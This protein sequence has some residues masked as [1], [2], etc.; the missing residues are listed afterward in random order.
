M[1]VESENCSLRT[2]ARY[3]DLLPNLKVFSFLWI[4]RVVL[5]VFKKGLSHPRLK[6]EGEV[7]AQ[8]ALQPQT[9]L[10]LGWLVE[11]GHRV[12][13]RYLHLLGVQGKSCS[14]SSSSEETLLFVAWLEA[15]IFLSIA[16]FAS[17]CLFGCCF[18]FFL[19]LFFFFFF[20]AL[21]LYAF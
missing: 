9:K 10:S 1:S 16:L 3:P 20:F 15:V 19:I 2:S 4:V 18:S 8:W 7:S 6:W 13:R 14:L 12:P 17:T 21:W 5:A 11:V